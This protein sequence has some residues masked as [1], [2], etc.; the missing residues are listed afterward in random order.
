MRLDWHG[1]MA[2]RGNAG[3]VGKLAQR[4]DVGLS[5]IV[6]SLI[7]DIG[8]CSLTGEKTG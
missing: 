7:L 2:D 5:G 3:G 1:N 4:S 8:V 6:L